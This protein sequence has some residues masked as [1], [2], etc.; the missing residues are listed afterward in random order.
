MEEE[1]IKSQESESENLYRT[2]SLLFKDRKLVVFPK[3][4]KLSLAMFYFSR[5]KDMFPSEWMD[6]KGQKLT[7]IVC[8]DA[9]SI[10]GAQ[11]LS[12]C[13]QE[14]RKQ[15]DLI[16]ASRHIKRIK[17]IKW[18]IDGPLKYIKGLSGSRTLAAELVEQMLD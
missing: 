1:H 15:V 11:V 10:A 9:L 12:N 13:V 3:E 18:S 5:V 8:L 14:P 7:H 16:A 2:L 4:E 6:Y 17:G